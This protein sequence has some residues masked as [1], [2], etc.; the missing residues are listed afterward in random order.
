MKR[1]AI[2]RIVIYSLLFLVLSSIL[3]AALA[4]DGFMFLFGEGDGTVVEHSG[5]V[6]ADTTR[7]LEIDWAGGNVTI[8][9]GESDHIFFYDNAPENCQYKTVYEC[10]EYTLSISYGKRAIS[11][12]KDPAKDLVIEVPA[13]WNCEELEINGAGLVINIENLD[14]NTLELDGAGCELNFSGAVAYVDIDGAGAKLDFNCTTRPEQLDFD[15]MG[16]DLELILPKGCGFTVNTNGLGCDLN[17][18]LSLEE[19]SGNKVHGN[20]ECAINIDGLGCSISIAESDECAHEWDLGYPAVEPGSGQQ[21]MVFTCL[22]CGQNKT[23]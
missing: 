14:I 21:M 18:H 19:K 12:G 5:S 7:R 17:T 8:R 11:V 16:C 13:D 6:S 15:G 2:A 10:D 1:N 23:E 22:L 20:G 3:I 9:R 4:L